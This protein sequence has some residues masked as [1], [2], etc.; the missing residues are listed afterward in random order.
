VTLSDFPDDPR[1]DRD[2]STVGAVKDRMDSGTDVFATLAWGLRRFALLVVAMVLALG[3]LVPLA[4]SQRSEVYEAT[5]QVGPISPLQLSNTTPLPKIAETVFNNGA[6]EQRV[7]G[8]LGQDSGNVIPSRVRLVAAQDNVVL[9]VGA[10][11]SSAKLAMNLANEAATTFSF[12]LNKYAEAVATFALQ[13][14]AVQAKKVPKLAGGYAS[15]ALGL[16][17]GLL[18]GVGLVGL[19]LVIRRPVVHP[20]TARDV[21]GSPV[22]GRITLPRHGP[23]TGGDSR[24]IGLL[25]R[26][27]SNTGCPTVL[28][29]APRSGQADRLAGLMKE[30]FVRMAELRRAQQRNEGAQAGPPVPNVAAPDSAEAWLTAADSTYTVLVAPEGISSRKLRGFTDGHD[31]GGSRG[32]VLLNTRRRG[33]KLPTSTR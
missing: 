17:A 14:R 20:S 19:I 12:E 2:Q 30:S 11:A 10:S 9:E 28:V 22:L 16:L 7:R 8:L 32:V 13:H 29:V 33:V 18:A 15:V 5:A 23:P 3:V 6:V 27:L 25:C 1:D 31:T 26:R 4:L 24:A 21:T